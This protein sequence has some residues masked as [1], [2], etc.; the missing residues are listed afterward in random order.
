MSGLHVSIWQ[1]LIYHFYLICI[2]QPKSACNFLSGLMASRP[3][4]TSASIFLIMY[5]KGS[6]WYNKQAHLLKRAILRLA[7]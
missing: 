2:N 6:D 5:P 1:F 7:V 4:S 3:F